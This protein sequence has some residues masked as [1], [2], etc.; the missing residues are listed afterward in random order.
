MSTVIIIQ[1]RMGSTRLP[2]KV[3]V[4][5]NG[6]HV[7][8][9]VIERCRRVKLADKVIVATTD[10]NEDDAIEAFC[11]TLDVPCYRGSE[12][13][14]LGRY[15]EAAV[16]HHATVVVRVTSDCPLLDP[17]ICDKVI[18]MLHN[19]EEAVYCSNDLERTFPRGLDVEVFRMSALQEAYRTA[20]EPYQREHVTPYI[21]EANSP[22]FLLCLKNEENLS[23]HR[24][25]LDTEEDM[26]FMIELFKRMD[27]GTEDYSWK[28]VVPII[29]R[30]PD[31]S[32]INNRVQQKKLH[33]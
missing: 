8:Q 21:Y 2:G 33:N 9:H 15:Y 3:M 4:K 16:L 5:L 18:S 22:D 1:A 11:L 29:N 25:T 10:N 32:S 20:R 28:S 23:H 27:T 7:L 30:H 12:Q 13:D 17:E 19:S 26:K 6:R 24:W 31:I 14:V